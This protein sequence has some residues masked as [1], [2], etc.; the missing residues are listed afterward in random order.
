MLCLAWY[1]FLVVPLGLALALG[2]LARWYLR[3]VWVWAL[4]VERQRWAKDA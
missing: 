4:T 2:L 3:R 1:W